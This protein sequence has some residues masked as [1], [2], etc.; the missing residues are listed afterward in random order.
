[1]GLGAY[2]ADPSSFPPSTVIYENTDFVAIHDKYP[3]A[4]V[5]VLLLPRSAQHSLLHPIEA[6]SA[7]AEFLSAVRAEAAKLKALAARELQRRLGHCS[8][9]E[10]AREA[11]LNG[12][13]DPDAMAVDLDAGT[14]NNDG[15]TSTRVALPPGRDWEAEIRVGVHAVPSMS[16]L[17]I[18]VMSRDMHSRTMRHRKH[19]NSFNTP[20]LI[21]LN[22]FPLDETDPR[23]NTKR[24]G[25]LDWD[26]VC[27]RCGKNF[28][29][30]FARL[31]E[32]LE[33]EF[34]EWVRV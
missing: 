3:K 8:K 10:A 1:M 29:N 2:I 9:A 15:E 31:K 26:M 27:W 6:L 11:V 4:T 25:Y 33:D 23:R 18:H 17:H 32:H 12:D 13:A 7:D 16:H 30:R 24:E 34:K 5:H 22:S 14:E 19:Y 28:K 21:D 20:F